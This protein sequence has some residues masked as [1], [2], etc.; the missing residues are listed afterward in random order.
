MRNS[1][2]DCSPPA[3]ARSATG[4]RSDWTAP[5]RSQSLAW[6][7]IHA[8]YPSPRGLRLT[9]LGLSIGLAAAFVL[10]KVVAAFL[11]ETP[12]S[13]WP[14]Y[15]GTASLLVCGSLVACFVPAWRAS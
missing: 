5:P 2:E 8:S 12:A 6:S 7:A 10:R 11:F 9:A 14:S 3:R 13:D 4:F 15:A 1:Q